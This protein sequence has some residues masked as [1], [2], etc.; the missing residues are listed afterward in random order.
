MI[1]HCIQKLI[2]RL[3]FYEY[4]SIGYYFKDF[5]NATQ[6]LLLLFLSYRPV[7]RITTKKALKHRYF[8]ESPRG[9]K[10]IMLPTFPEIRNQ[11]HEQES[12]NDKSLFNSKKDMSVFDIK[13]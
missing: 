6:D 13:K 5:T 10:P 11:K 3:P 12:K 1:H 4:D 8:E 2:A 7:D 9:C